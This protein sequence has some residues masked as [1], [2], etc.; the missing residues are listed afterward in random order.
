MKSRLVVM[1]VFALGLAG[2]GDDKAPAKVASAPPSVASRGVLK[3]TR[4]SAQAISCVGSVVV[5]HWDARKLGQGNE[6]GAIQIWADTGTDT[7]ILFAEG[8]SVGAAKTGKW[9]IPGLKFIAKSMR[10]NEILDQF[11]ISGP[12]C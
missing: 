5:V 10:T 12:K 6:L 8:E 7:P 3:V 9:V 1:A 11:V 4:E 2:C